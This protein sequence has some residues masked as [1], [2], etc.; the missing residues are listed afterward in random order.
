MS[1]EKR[2]AVLLATAA[3][4]HAGQASRNDQEVNAKV[5]SLRTRHDE[6]PTTRNHG[7]CAIQASDGAH[8]ALPARRRM[9]R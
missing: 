6:R 1:L 4:L 7:D 3:I 9:T 5:S 2:T 8:N